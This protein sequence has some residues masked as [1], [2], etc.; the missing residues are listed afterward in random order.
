MDSQKDFN[1]GDSSKG[2]KEGMQP[3]TGNNQ[4]EPFEFLKKMIQPGRV[5]K[6][7]KNNLSS[8]EVW[9]VCRAVI[10]EFKKEQNLMEVSAP[11]TVIGDVHGNFHDLYRALLA[12]TEQDITDEQKSNFSTRQFVRDKY[13]FLGNYIDKGPRSIECI[14]LL[15]AFKICFPQ[16]YILL[17]GPHEC[18]SVNSS[19]FLGVMET[20][21][22]NHFKK[23]HKKFNEAFSWMP[24]AAVVGQ[25]IL[26]VHG[27]ISPRLTSWEDIRKIKRPLKDATEDPLATDLLFAD[28]LDFDL[29]HIPTRKPKYEFNV[30]RNMSVMYN[31]AAVTQF[32]EKFNLKLIIRSHMKVPF[33]YRFFSE[34]RLITIFNSTGFQNESNYGAVLKIDGNAKITIIS[35]L[36]QQSKAEVQEKAHHSDMTSEC[37]TMSSKGP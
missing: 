5:M 33:G 4:F 30:I 34:K 8:N 25:K 10:D 24:L 15:F 13:V 3:S 22:P 14:C 37:N 2:E 18:P 23:I 32:C 6:R 19:E 31:E 20:F 27:G 9:S 7:S 12:R 26:C 11:V 17:R 28:T 16:K 1:L 21:S 29:I 36:P 35:L